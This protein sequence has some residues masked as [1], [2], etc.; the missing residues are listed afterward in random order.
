MED[1]RRRAGRD[2]RRRSGRGP[3][4]RQTAERAAARGACD[5]VHDEARR[6]RRAQAERLGSNQ[7]VV[8]VEVYVARHH[9]VSD[10]EEE[11]RLLMTPE[12]MADATARLGQRQAQLTELAKLVGHFRRGLCAESF[13]PE[14]ADRFCEVWLRTEMQQKFYVVGN[15]SPEDG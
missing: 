11:A 4:R 3:E 13:P 9:R 14:V 2:G 6:A 15:D 10:P 12:F 5:G 7:C 8:V 1:A